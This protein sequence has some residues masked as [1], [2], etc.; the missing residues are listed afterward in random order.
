MQSQEASESPAPA[1]EAPREAG[2]S[3][4]ESPASASASMEENERQIP[5]DPVSLRQLGMVMTDADS[6]LSAPSV[7]T[8]MVAQSSSPLRRPTFV[9]ASLPCSAASSPV[10]SAAKRE[11]DRIPVMP[12]TRPSLATVTALRSLARQHSAAL[13]HYVAS[14]SPSAAPVALTRSASRAEGRSMA[15]HDDEDDVGTGVPEQEESFTCGALCMFI[16][17]FSRRKQPGAAGAAAA[18]VVSS[19]QRQQSATARRSRSSVVSRLASLERFECGSWS[20][21]PPPPPP[22][23]ATVVTAAHDVVASFALGAAK[24]SSCAAYDDDADA[25]VKMAF[26]FDG[27]PMAPRG[28]LMMKKSASQRQEPVMKTMAACGGEPRGILKKSASTRQLQKQDSDSAATPCR[29]SSASQR[30]VRFSTAS[31]SSSPC[32][33]PRLARAR[34]EFNAFMEAQMA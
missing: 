22:Q 34:A 6:P 19:V 11:D 5:V 27:E 31:P 24:V 18:A 3:G 1:T 28:V 13:A 30:H 7:L 10:H 8:E 26:V 29:P 17:G 12:A 15:P 33:T 20:P 16:P 2:A 25:P 14:P 21:A 4:D 9:G 23:P 32:I